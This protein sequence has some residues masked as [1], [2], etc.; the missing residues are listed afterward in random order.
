MAPDTQTTDPCWFT[1]NGNY[2]CGIDT[3]L[4]G[5][6]QIDLEGV[7]VAECT[8]Q[9]HFPP[10]QRPKQTPSGGSITFQNHPQHG[11]V[12][13][14]NVAIQMGSCT[15][16]CA[17]T[18]V[19]EFDESYSF[20]ADNLQ[21]TPIPGGANP[22]K[23]C[24]VDGNGR[25]AG[26]F[27]ADC[28]FNCMKGVIDR[29]SSKDRKGLLP[30]LGE[31]AKGMLS[32]VMQDALEGM[33]NCMF[34]QNDMSN[35]F[36]D[37]QIQSLTKQFSTNDTTTHR[38]KKSGTV[39]FWNDP[40]FAAQLREKRE[41]KWEEYLATGSLPRKK[42]TRTGENLSQNIFE[43]M[44]ITDGNYDSTV[45]TLDTLEDLQK[46]VGMVVHTYEVGSLV[47]QDK[48]IWAFV[49]NPAGALR[50]QTNNIFNSEEWGDY[51]ECQ[52]KLLTLLDE[53]VY[54]GNDYF[55]L[56]TKLWGDE[57]RS[58]ITGKTIMEALDDFRDKTKNI[59]YSS[60]KMED[61]WVVVFDKVSN[62]LGDVL[63]GGEGAMY[64]PIGVDSP[65]GSVQA[66]EK[67]EDWKL[68]LSNL[69]RLYFGSSSRGG[70]YASTGGGAPEGCTPT[71]PGLAENCPTRDCQGAVPNFECHD[72]PSCCVAHEKRKAE[73]A[74]CESQ[75]WE[76]RKQCMDREKESFLQ[77]YKDMCGTT[78]GP[79]VDVQT[80]LGNT[81]TVKCGKRHFK[82]WV[83]PILDEMDKA[84]E[85]ASQCEY[86][87]KRWERE[88]RRGGGVRDCCWE[89]DRST[90]PPTYTDKCPEPGCPE[91]WKK[92][93]P[94][95]L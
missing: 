40:A 42:P 94:P 73:L 34:F 86:K 18:W 56:L 61:A 28:L 23:K 84:R 13:T 36:Y 79:R 92:G 77:R 63:D 58:P 4:F 6:I 37:Q 1:I 76:R 8:C 90:N 21:G 55:S 87:W 66:G 19:E 30:Q 10:G 14:W 27:E 32:E 43:G 85:H 88:I 80:M 78:H 16:A 17:N 9:S 48:E 5:N 64:S 31:I 25:V 45:S 24:D 57:E 7:T 72:C 12:L 50:Q 81:Y 49:D 95:R 47:Q 33:G 22:C 44:L 59:I 15:R 54:C 89:I 67:V 68:N 38:G 82:K 2:K 91:E 75:N 11:L 53:A 74:K 70:G 46:L 39:G 60:T 83:Q 69:G 35:N 71:Y 41:A 51:A 20:D 52:Q 62:I 26:K 3:T 29:G 65:L 93:I